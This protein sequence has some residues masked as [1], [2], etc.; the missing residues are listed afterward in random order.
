MFMDSSLRLVWLLNKSTCVVTSEVL[1][2]GN[3]KLTRLPCYSG[4]PTTPSG[5]RNFMHFHQH[6]RTVYT[7]AGNQYHR[8]E[9]IRARKSV[10][11]E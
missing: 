10:D 2:N 9:Y 11:A 4:I 7:P 5:I 6:H 8:S 3:V 1:P